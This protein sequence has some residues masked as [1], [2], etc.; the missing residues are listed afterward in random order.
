MAKPVELTL[1]GA[2]LAGAGVTSYFIWKNYFAAQM[3]I[4]PEAVG[5]QGEQG[6]AVVRVQRRERANGVRPELQAFLDWWHTNGPFQLVV[7]PDGGVRT[8]G[9]KQRSFYDRGMSK[10]ATLAQTPH[11]H[12]SALDLYPVGF[13]AGKPL[14]TQPAIKQQFKEMGTIAKRFGFTWG[15]DWGWDYPHIEMK[16]W[17]TYPMPRTSAP[18]IAGLNGL[19]E[20][21]PTVT[22]AGW[23][24]PNLLLFGGAAALVVYQVFIRAD[25]GP[26]TIRRGATSTVKLAPSAF[27]G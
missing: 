10:A 25:E 11:G 5:V 16:D 17:K 6:P 2:G 27:N 9:A 7:A 1:W 18:N 26:R 21:G 8:D 24:T 19:G 20:A 22:P 4:S 12:S 15:G 3:E 13:N 23:S 14:D